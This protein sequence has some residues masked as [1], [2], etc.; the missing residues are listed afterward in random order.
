MEKFSK[1][2]CISVSRRMPT[3]VASSHSI[4][5]QLMKINRCLQIESKSEDSRP[6]NPAP[7]FQIP[8]RNPYRMILR[9][10]Y[11]EPLVALLAF[12][13]GIWLWDHYFGKSAGY[14][15]GT[16]E[17]ALIKIDRDLRLADAM[18]GDSA[19]L[20]WLA[21]VDKPADVRS[22]GLTALRK[23]SADGSVS[24][25][26]LEAY[27]LL[28]ATVE[29]LPL[30]ETL[31]EA[32]QGQVNLDFMETSVALANHRGTWWQARWVEA[33]EK[34]MPPARTWR[35]VY[36]NDSLLLRSRAI[37]ARSWVWLLGIAGIAFI[38]RTLLGLKHSLRAKPTGYA[39]AWPLSLGVTVFLVATLAWIGFTTALE[40]GI[41]A[42]P[43]LH[44]LVGILLD[45][46]AR[47]LPALIALG[48]LFRRPAHVVRVLGLDRSLAPA[49]VLG[50]FSLLM[51]ADLLLRTTIGGN[52]VE[53][54]GGLSTSDSG[55]WGLTFAIV[56]ACLLA[57]LAEEIL[58]RGI[59]FR[60]FWSRLGVLP[61]GLIS[62]A[63]FATLHFYDG[64][65]LLSVGIF[66][67]SC[68]LLY[69]STGSL[70]SCILLHLLY[71]SSIKL[72]EWLIYHGPLS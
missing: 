37:L 49:A 45:S 65:G 60:A 55:I 16:E 7:S 58:Y 47:L 50:V 1:N 70:I 8:R 41:S 29:G 28:K 5:Q 2:Y 17:I 61:A 11:P 25:S 67:L 43:G 13:L 4:F 6:I 31:A 46:A 52:S 34:D 10:E 22:D 21:G 40:L 12:I 72:P 68:A 62:A 71:N 51:F 27:A 39:K 36:H 69:A 15:P 23:L 42:L 63:I 3:K 38:P 26:G 66:G 44:P 59:L 20:R 56:S 54:G 19:L 32:M 33:M 64:Y 48:L 53:P 30:R 9:R 24:L 18:D 35:N 14:A 57:P